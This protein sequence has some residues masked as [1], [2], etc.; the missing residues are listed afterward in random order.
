[1]TTMVRSASSTKFS[2][3]K[4]KGD[5]RSSRSRLRLSRSVPATCLMIIVHVVFS[6]MSTYHVVS[7]LVFVS[8]ADEDHQR[9]HEQQD[10]NS[11]H[12]FY[13]RYNTYPPYCGDPTEMKRRTIPDLQQQ[14]QPNVQTKLEHISVV[15]RHGA[16]TPASGK[17]D[18]WPGYWDVPQGVWDCNLKTIMLATEPN[19]RI[20]VGP[21]SK[22]E[23]N[24]HDHDHGSFLVEKVYDAFLEGDRRSSSTSS[25]FTPY[26][27][28]L[29]GTCQKGQLIQQ[30]YDQQVTNGQILRNR[31]IKDGTRRRQQEDQ[32]PPIDGDDRLI[33]FD[34]STV[35]TTGDYPFSSRN[36][37]YRSDDDQRT[38][39]SGQVLLKSL[40][41]PEVQT[42][43]TKHNG[44]NQPIIDH[45]TADRHLDVLS[46]DRVDNDVCTEIFEKLELQAIQ[47]DEYKA[48]NQSDESVLMRQLIDEELSHPN[49]FTQDCMM[50]AICTDRLIPDVIND[51]AGEISTDSTASD[52]PREENDND[53]YTRKF[54]R[55]RFVRLRDYLIQREM[56]IYRFNDSE[57]AKRDMSALWMEILDHIN[58]VMDPNQDH[59]KMSLYSGHDSTIIPLMASLGGKMWNNTDFP[60][61]ASMMI[62]EIHKVVNDVSEKP[63]FPSGFAFRLVYNGRVLTWLVDSG[64]GQDD[65]NA[66]H[67]TQ[68]SQLCDIS[69][70][71]N[72][73]TSFATRSN[74]GCGQD[75]P[76]D[77]DDDASSG[78][79]ADLAQ[80]GEKLL[81]TAEKTAMA[82]PDLFLALS[83]AI[84]FVLG[85][86]LACRSTCNRSEHP[87]EKQNESEL[88]LT[89]EEPD[90][91]I[92]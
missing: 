92:D 1:M 54:G 13:K 67:C 59:V 64:I 68:F 7:F 45:H 5:R 18:C 79:I 12:S 41:G 8:A 48:F 90:V 4:K 10:E 77:S 69:I 53:P 80:Q 36:L 23:N 87:I 35:D 81:T 88:V 82:N 70:L 19:P 83:V 27:N 17:H 50:T 44:T 14:L 76:I 86:F 51:Y 39:A 26:K 22:T 75:D 66:V 62:I 20:T 52:D 73:V 28:H 74:R 16:R 60:Y 38:V 43:V 6:V 58:P 56:M 63:T 89:E 2:I 61:Y 32:E 30:G 55:N 72:R 46:E 49:S 15:I 25:V 57:Y 85:L 34:A 71:M 11:S 24:D 21:H 78:F 3:E 33:L 31:Y 40:F 91:V 29:N 84:S 42:F 47:S 65:E 9:R 37:R